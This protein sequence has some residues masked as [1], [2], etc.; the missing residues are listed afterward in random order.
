M[1]CRARSM[2]WTLPLP[3]G[4]TLRPWPPS[5]LLVYGRRY[6]ALAQDQFRPGISTHK[7]RGR[8]SFTLSF[9]DREYSSS[10]AYVL[11]TSEPYHM[12][13]ALNVLDRTKHQGRGFAIST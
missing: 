6:L 10:Q 13:E 8:F 12:P 5:L 11:H 7:A 1:N 3:P 4:S 2:D 9:R